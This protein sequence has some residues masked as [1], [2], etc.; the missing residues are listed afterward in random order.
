MTFPV[1]GLNLV[2]SVLRHTPEQL[3]GFIRRMPGLKLNT[4]IVQHNYGWQRYGD[5][6]LE[7]AA[8][9]GVELCMMT[10]SPLTFYRYVDVKP[11]WLAKREDGTLFTDRLVCETQLCSAEPEAIEAFAY[12]AERWLADLPAAIRHIHVRPGDGLNFCRCPVCRTRTES[13]R[14]Q[15]FL[16]AFARVVAAKRPDLKWESDVYALRY[17]LPTDRTACS[18]MDR[19]MFDTFFRTA[20][21]P[22]GQEGWRHDCMNGCTSEPNPDAVEPNVWHGKRLTEWAAAFPG[23]VYVHENLMAQG[24][25]GVNS[26]NTATQLQ[27][28]KTYRALGLQGVCYEAYEPGYSFFT[29]QIEILAAAMAD[30]SSAADYRPT[31][32]EQEVSSGRWKMGWFCADPA[33]PVERYIEDP[34]ECTHV[35]NYADFIGRPSPETLRRMFMFTLEHS[36]R[37]DCLMAGF[38][39]CDWARA[40]GHV[41]F[42]AAQPETR[43]L[44][45]FRKLWDFM[46]E[47]PLDTDPRRV[48]CELLLNAV[49][50]AR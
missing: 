20:V 39:G 40:F 7:E 33:F 25:L 50:S 18:T 4:L 19:I 11:H 37:F 49:E 13:D 41:D 44:L 48:A 24:L 36:D 42:S 2:E 17:R 5:L 10:F 27:D 3:R 31:P 29:K 9:A 35:R 46:E 22:I 34:V 21:V 16:N 15:P 23:K 6:I 30:E 26:Q 8:A 12:G 45:S 14:W 32:F 38:F 28:L 43:R 47:V 1:R